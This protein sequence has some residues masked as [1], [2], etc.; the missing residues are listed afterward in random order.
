MFYPGP[1]GTLGYFFVVEVPIEERHE[2]AKFFGQISG[3]GPWGPL[4]SPG[5]TLGPLGSTGIPWGLLGYPCRGGFA[6][7]DLPGGGGQGPPRG[8]KKGNIEI[9]QIC[10]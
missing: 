8:E 4:G 7:P 2:R 5:V 6:T 1:Q 3:L 9:Y 10:I